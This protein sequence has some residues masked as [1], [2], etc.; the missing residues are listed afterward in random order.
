MSNQILSKGDFRDV[1]ERMRGLSSF[2]GVREEVEIC[3]TKAVKAYDHLI[4]VKLD[5]ESELKDAHEHIK[6]VLGAVDKGKLNWFQKLTLVVVG[7]IIPDL[8]NHFKAMH[9]MA[10]RYKHLLE[11]KCQCTCGKCASKQQ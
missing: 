4:N 5:L 7:A 3:R 2:P 8:Q 9:H 1:F 11:P 6:A 10:I